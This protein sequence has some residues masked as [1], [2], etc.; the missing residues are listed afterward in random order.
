MKF[1]TYQNIGKSFLAILLLIGA[2]FL[3]TLFDLLGDF[4]DIV[5][6][7][8]K[9]TGKIIKIEQEKYGMT[10]YVRYRNEGKQRE[11]EFITE[12]RRNEK[13]GNQVSVHYNKNNVEDMYIYDPV[14]LIGTKVLILVIL[15]IVSSFLWVKFKGVIQKRQEE[16][17]D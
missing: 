4:S 5:N 7:P 14:T 9:T 2:V 1:S 13:V 17:L 12:C 3:I 8:D 6:C 16:I 11:I 15:M 10:A